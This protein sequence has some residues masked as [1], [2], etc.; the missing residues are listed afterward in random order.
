M[1]QL[2]SYQ[3]G[4]IALARTFVTQLEALR[5]YRTGGEQK[6]TVTQGAPQDAARPA[7]RSSVERRRQRIA[8]P[9]STPAYAPTPATPLKPQPAAVP[10]ELTRKK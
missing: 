4:C 6:I 5:L 1:P 3:R 10:P 9:R 2:D 7:A 8:D